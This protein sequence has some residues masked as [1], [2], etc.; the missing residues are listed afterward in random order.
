MQAECI[1]PTAKEQPQQVCNL[2]RL[3]YRKQIE[4][5]IVACATGGFYK[6]PA[7]GQSIESGTDLTITWDPSCMTADAADIYLYAPGAVTSRIHMWENVNFALGSY[8]TKLQAGWWNSTGSI[9]LQLSIV[10]YN[11]PPFLASLPAGPVFTA[12]VGSG[13]SNSGTTVSSTIEDVNNFGSQHTGLSHGKVAAAVILPLLI[14]GGLIFAAWMK[15]RRGKTED[16]RKR[17][18]EA[19][20]KRMST[21][22]T[23]WKSITPGGASAA[24]RSSMAISAGASENRNSS[25]SFGN[26]RPSSTVA[27]EGGQAGIGSKGMCMQENGSFEQPQMSQLRSGPRVPSA[28]GN[29]PRISFAA[30]T[31]V[32]RVSFA[33]D[34]RPSGESRRGVS[35]AF[36]VGEAPPMPVRQY[37]DEMSPTQT[38]GPV[39]LSPDDIS[40]RMSESAS[41][42][43]ID[44]YMPAL[45]S[46]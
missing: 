28:T 12:T 39:S 18:S 14:V 1:K 20:D 11:T 4:F 27:T 9:S 29:L 34:S 7:S 23:D 37:S 5:F 6:S 41:R 21:I 30:D 19:V 25:F 46:T 31:R 44:D 43:S 3:A 13:D 10:E 38:H 33:A 8:N 24:I 40:A 35:R 42:P 16:K 45:S 17:W 36:H 22:S 26:I 15:F 32:S 2:N